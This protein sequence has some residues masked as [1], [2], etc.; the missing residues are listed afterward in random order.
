MFKVPHRSGIPEST[1]ARA[2]VRHPGTLKFQS[3]PLVPCCIRFIRPCPCAPLSPSLSSSS[4]FFFALRASSSLASTRAELFR[5]ALLSL[6]RRAIALA[7]L[8]FPRLPRLFLT[9]RCSPFFPYFLRLRGSESRIEAKITESGLLP[10]RIGERFVLRGSKREIRFVAGCTR[11]EFAV[12]C[13]T[14]AMLVLIFRARH[15]DN[16]VPISLAVN[17]Y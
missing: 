14:F 9:P 7:P 10:V 16:R 1:L 8:L 3:T 15:E 5:A 2:R 11:F 12:G 6:S 13:D 17:L 4:S